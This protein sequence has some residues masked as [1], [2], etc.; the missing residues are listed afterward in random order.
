MSPRAGLDLQTVLQ[1][2]AEIADTHGLDQVTLA[3]I[4]QKLGIRP[5]SLYNHVDGLPGLRN[6]LAV[7]GMKQLADR[8]TC[9]AVGRS[10]DDAVHA[11]GESYVA[12]ARAHPGLYEATLRAPDPRD[13]ELQKAAEE[14][15]NVVLRVL[16]AYGLEEE[17][18]LNAVR[19]LRSLLHG[20]ASLEQ[21][22]GFG[23][24]LDHDVSLRFVIDTFL[25]G[26]H[27][28]EA[29]KKQAGRRP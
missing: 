8:L 18:A 7:F 16:N 21:K 6:K 13:S 1:T 26:I 28:L 23:L 24:P 10:K 3:T 12:F 25:A 19:G 15:M 22:G 5:P 17:A 2:A 27:A 14:L 29:E 4:A 20:F 11:M 9:A